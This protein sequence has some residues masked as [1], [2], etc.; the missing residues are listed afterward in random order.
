MCVR[1]CNVCT[2][3]R[4]TEKHRACSNKFETEF[5]PHSDKKVIF[6]LLCLQSNSMKMCTSVLVP[7]SWESC[8]KCWFQLKFP[9]QVWVMRNTAST[10]MLKIIFNPTQQQGLVFH[11]C[12]LGT[13]CCLCCLC[14]LQLLGLP[15]ATSLQVFTSIKSLFSLLTTLMGCFILL[16][17]WKSQFWSD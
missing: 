3:R 10:V 12:C 17:S 2:N 9:R 16:F 11:D 13:G 15:E 7:S 5:W 1:M 14:C 8:W 4:T 6:K